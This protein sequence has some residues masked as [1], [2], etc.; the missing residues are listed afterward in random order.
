M[1]SLNIGSI[2]HTT[3][4][5]FLSEKGLQNFTFE[6]LEEVAPDKLSEREKYWIAFYE[7]NKQLNSNIGG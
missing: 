1:S 7:T 6:I 5:N 3:F 2:A 4:H